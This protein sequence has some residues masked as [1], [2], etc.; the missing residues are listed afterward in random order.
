MLRAF[1]DKK[2][3]RGKKCYSHLIMMKNEVFL[4]LFH[5]FRKVAFAVEIVGVRKNSIDTTMYPDTAINGKK[6]ARII[7]HT[8]RAAPSCSLCSRAPS[9][10]SAD[11][12]TMT[13]G[14]LIADRMIATKAS[15]AASR[16]NPYITTEVLIA[17]LKIVFN[18]FIAPS[19][20]NP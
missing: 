7:E 10:F 19:R 5:L 13:S 16:F 1:F 11:L 4:R 20:S 8:I 6:T 15:V 18:I 3:R 14:V 17:D 9:S 2:T 12:S